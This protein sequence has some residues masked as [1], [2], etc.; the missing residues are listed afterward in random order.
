MENCIH[1]TSLLLLLTKSSTNSSFS[2]TWGNPD[3]GKLGHSPKATSTSARSGSR[4]YG[5]RNYADLDQV[6]FV[7]GEL[8]E[9]K[10][11]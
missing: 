3:T 1:K 6:D 9:K 11:K 5:P 7:F 2:L 10:V 4:S 8:T